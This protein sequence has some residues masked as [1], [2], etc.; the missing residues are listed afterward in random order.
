MSSVDGSLLTTGIAVCYRDAMLQ[1]LYP[2]NTS[3]STFQRHNSRA[4]KLNA[5]Q[6]YDIRRKYNEGMSQGQLSREYNISS[7]QIGRIVRGESWGQ[8]MPP[9]H[10]APTAAIEASR[11]R[12]EAQLRAMGLAG[13]STTKESEK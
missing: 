8:Y 1:Q 13:D 6:V 2:G 5:S 9:P 3:M 7:G 4:A 10:E 11:L 12:F